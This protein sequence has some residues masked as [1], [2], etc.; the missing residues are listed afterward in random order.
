MAWDLFDKNGKRKLRPGS[1]KIPEPLDKVELE[2]VRADM[3]ELIARE[4]ENGDWDKWVE[5][6]RPIQQLR[7]LDRDILTISVT[8][9]VDGQVIPTPVGIEDAI[10]REIN[11]RYRNRSAHRLERQEMPSR[12]I[13]MEADRQRFERVRF[14]T[15]QIT[16]EIFAHYV[17]RPPSRDDLERANCP[18]HGLGHSRCGWCESC[19]R[20]RFMCS[21]GPGMTSTSHGGEPT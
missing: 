17:G 13:A 16:E 3:A 19:Q 9:T 11:D 4:K 6:Q 8:L 20:P 14:Y 7:S 12:I 5:S 18:L 2:I 1:G 10:S 21:H 15:G